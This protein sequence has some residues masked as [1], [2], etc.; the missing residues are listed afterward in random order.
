RAGGPY[1]YLRE[2][3][4]PIPA[5]LFGWTEFTVARAGSMATLAAAFSR[6]FVQVAPPPGAINGIVWQAAV[7]VTAI[8]IVTTINIL[9]TRN[10]A[11]LQ[12]V[13]TALKVG[14]L[15]A[16]ITLPF[17]VGGGEAGNLSPVWPE[18]I[19]GTFF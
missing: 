13:G 14:G 6:Y 11:G 12:V 5:F 15:L 4:G 19:G 17:A 7:A 18:R 16:I 10:G 3:Y 1:V 8:A 9:S 2:A